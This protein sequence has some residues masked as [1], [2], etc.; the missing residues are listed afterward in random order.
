[1]LKPPVNNYLVT[2]EH[3]TVMVPSNSFDKHDQVN[4]NAGRSLVAPMNGEIIT[5]TKHQ[6][7]SICTKETCY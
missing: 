5:S 1:M 3:M 7:G 4:S 6:S 2:N